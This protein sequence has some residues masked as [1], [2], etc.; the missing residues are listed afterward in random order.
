MNNYS[1]TLEIKNILTMPLPST[2]ADCIG[3]IEVLTE[4]QRAVGNRLRHLLQVTSQETDKEGELLSVGIFDEE[5]TDA[6]I[7]EDMKSKTSVPKFSPRPR[8]E[9]VKDITSNQEKD[10]SVIG[11][12]KILSSKRD[13][14]FLKNL[15]FNRDE[16]FLKTLTTQT[17]SR[18]LSQSLKDTNGISMEELA[19]SEQSSPMI[20]ALKKLQ[21][22]YIQK[23]TVKSWIRNLSS[24]FLLL[25]ED[26]NGYIDSKE[27][28]KMIDKL[29]LSRKLKYSLKSK[30]NEIDFDN[31]RNIS[32]DEFLGFFLLFPKFKEEVLMHACNNAPYTFNVGLSTIQ[33]WRL[34]V[35][36]TMEL[37]E[38]NQLSKI[39]YFFDLILTM[40][41]TVCICLEGLG[42][43]SQNWWRW[44]TYFWIISIF[45]AVQYV[46]GLL[47][48]KSKK[49]FITN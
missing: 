4:R 31:S 11:G 26:K 12:S 17:I 14:K 37:P 21:K 3:E 16:K 36:N 29:N 24:L 8:N 6:M 25:D 42:L 40:I 33:R 15:S 10:R 2:M 5:E 41:P 43:S 7:D 35:Y 32:V 44:N 22:N 48:C 34:R 1:S 38:Y 49:V 47:T 30:F 46:C 18:A 27:Y 39:L 20:I 19:T 13:E 9:L 28:S 23:K 45:F